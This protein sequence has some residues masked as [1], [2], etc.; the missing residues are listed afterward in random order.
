[1]HMCSCHGFTTALDR[2]WEFHFVVAG[3][4]KDA[5]CSRSTFSRHP[6]S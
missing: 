6:K 2:F 1:M 4:R 3:L 5:G